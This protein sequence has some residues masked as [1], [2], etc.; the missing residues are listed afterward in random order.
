MDSTLKQ[1]WL[2]ALR[3]GEYAQDYEALYDATTH[4]YCAI[5]VLFAIAKMDTT[6]PLSML[7]N[8]A[9]KLVGSHELFGKVMNLNDM[10]HYSFP[11]IADW[12][13]KNM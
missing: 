13:E 5:G 3:S 8:R 6:L 1:Q 2:D 11:V 7:Y 9:E 10:R 4:T 12:I